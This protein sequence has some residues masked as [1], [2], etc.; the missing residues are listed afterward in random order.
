MDLLTRQTLRCQDCKWKALAT[1]EDGWCYMFGELMISCL[2]W[3]PKK[4]DNKALQATPWK[5]VDKP[6]LSGRRA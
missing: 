1:K 3:T 5:G 2:K 6:E 4:S